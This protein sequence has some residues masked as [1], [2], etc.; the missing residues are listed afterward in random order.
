MIFVVG[1]TRMDA[2]TTKS[3]GPGGRSRVTSS[4]TERTLAGSTNGLE[5]EQ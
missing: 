3:I 5:S 2:L 1:S 4:V